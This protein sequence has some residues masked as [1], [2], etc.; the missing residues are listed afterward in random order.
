VAGR[1]SAFHAP[2]YVPSIAL[3][4]FGHFNNVVSASR[5]GEGK[6]WKRNGLKPTHDSS[7]KI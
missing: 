2:I 6:F 1:Q 3:W 7:F 4:Q 5:T